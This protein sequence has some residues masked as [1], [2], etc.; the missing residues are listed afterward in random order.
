MV[1]NSTFADDDSDD[2]DEEEEE[3]DTED[4]EVLKQ[5]SGFQ[6]EISQ[7]PYNYS[8]H[9]SLVTLLRKTEHFDKL[10]EARKSFSEFYPLTPALWI[11]WINDEQKIASS[12]EEKKFVSSLFE[13][14]VA[15][16]VSV[17]LWLEYCQV[18]IGGVGSQE[19]IKKAR[20]VFEAA[21]TSCGRNIAKGSHIWD[22]YRELE[23][24]LLSMFPSEGSPEQLEAHSD[25]RKRVDSLFRR[26]LR[27]PLQGMSSTFKE[28][29][30][31]LGG[32][33]DNNAVSDYNKATQKLKARQGFEDKLLSEDNNEFYLEYL[34]FELKEKDPVMIQQ[35]YERAITDNCLNETLWLDYL[36]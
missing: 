12:E 16:Y 9:L 31:F 36:R 7:N 6:E 33:V 2:M 4:P 23:S 34:Q 5:I 21:I 17:D 25:Q 18:C 27:I 35:L 32:E 19:G 22:A 13:T 30:E 14:G 15:D 10:R 8:A 11:D 26:Q 28:Y 1:L 24:I 29:K 3:E 20:D